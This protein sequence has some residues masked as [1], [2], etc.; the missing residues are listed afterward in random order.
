MQRKLKNIWLGNFKHSVNGQC[1]NNSSENMDGT[2]SLS[3]K[4]EVQNSCCLFIVVFTRTINEITVLC[5]YSTIEV[6]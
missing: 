3:F 5:G 2:A 1:N 4:F 6:S